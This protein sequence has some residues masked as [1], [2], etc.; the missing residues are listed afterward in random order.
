MRLPSIILLACALA[1]RHSRQAKETPSQTAVAA[2]ELCL[3]HASKGNP[4]TRPGLFSSD[5]WVDHRYLERGSRAED[6]SHRS[7]PPRLALF[8][9]NGK[10]KGRGSM[11]MIL[12]ARADSYWSSMID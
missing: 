5:K 9:A 12:E 4:M 10:K 11:P 1:V 8:P 6:K 3:P 7:E 2:K